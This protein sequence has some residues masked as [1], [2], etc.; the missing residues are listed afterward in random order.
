LAQRILPY[1]F[2]SFLLFSYLLIGCKGSKITPVGD[3]Y[4]NTTAHYNAYFYARERILEVEQNLLNYGER[5]YN[6]ILPIY[7]PMDSSFS[8]ANEELIEDVVKKASIAIQRHE[9]SKWVDDSYITVGKA[10]LFSLDF[11]NAV[12]TF[13]YVNVKSKDKDTRHL[14]LVWLFRTFVD[15]GEYNNATAVID[16]LQR[17]K[18]SKDNKRLFALFKARYYQLTDDLD[19]MVK[20]L[21]EAVPLETN[22]DERAKIYF[23]IGQVYQ[24]LTFDALAYENYQSCLQN[25]PPYE[26]SFYAKLNMASVTQLTNSDDLKT[27]RRYFRKLL[28][29]EKNIDFKDK[30]YYELAN[31]ELKQG[32]YDEAIEN[33]NYSIQSSTSNPRQKGYSYLQLAEVYYRHFKK[34]KTAQSYYDSTL[35]VLPKDE[36]NYEALSQRLEIL[37]AFVEQVTII[38]TQDSLLMLAKMP[39]DELDKYLDDYI[40]AKAKEAE[41]KEKAIAESK[42]G[43]RGNQ[44]VNFQTQ[45]R[46]INVQQQGTWYFYSASAVSQGR[47][48]FARVWGN[49]PLADNWRRSVKQGEI[50]ATVRD[51]EAPKQTAQANPDEA[52]A[53]ISKEDLIKTLP[54]TQEAQ[55]EAL[56][57]VEEA[58]F[59]LGN[60]YN[61]QLLEK[62][63]AGITFNTLI[64]R[65]PDSEHAPEAL[66]ELYLIYKELDSAIYSDYERQLIT[67]F[68]ESIF[69]KLIVNPRYREESSAASAKLQKM[70]AEAYGYYQRGEYKKAREITSEGLLAYDDNDFTDNMK[71][72]DVMLIAKLDDVYR[73][74]FEL[75]NFITTYSESELIPYAKTLVK[76]YDDFQLNLVNSAKAK[77]KQEFD[78]LHFFVIIYPPD[79]KLPDELPGKV[80]T[81]IKTNLQIQ[82]LTLG[83]LILDARRSM[84]LVNSFP[85]KKEAAEFYQ[86]FNS[87]NTLFK[88]YGTIKFYNF[89]I[90]RENF[91]VFYQ[92]KDLEAYLTFFNNNY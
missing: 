39:E 16:Y 60:I 71:L 84:I 11:P 48:E 8:K 19:N 41:D 61:F 49:R 3:V 57:K 20:N 4:H 5:N 91:N 47:Q 51:A 85:G 43:R 58:H 79:G 42:K 6:R 1:H 17:E 83:N 26:L 53:S 21:V 78:Q 30:I 87:N 14:S 9:N 46:E 55:N 36:P 90:T 80:D 54:L 92:T 33:Y 38:E 67:R 25:N 89:V 76:A 77:F 72:L 86:N 70:Y 32:N 81:Y 7:P 40:A 52:I 10:R 82:G 44:A 64:V 24:Q 66:Y 29:D 28:K 75:N 59:Q 12:E 73:Y 56:A 23:I 62:D 69:A 34:Y 13:K 2:L 74:Q 88:E 50:A 22:H 15:A 31:F 37:T 68:P 65:F 27:V 63:N 45:G 35:S 18:L